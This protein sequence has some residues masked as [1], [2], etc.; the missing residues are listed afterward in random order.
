[1]NRNLLYFHFFAILS[2]YIA[3]NLPEKKGNN[4]KG[5]KFLF[6]FT[7]DQLKLWYLRTSLK[8]LSI[9]AEMA[10]TIFT[11]KGKE[12]SLTLWKKTANKFHQMLNLM[13]LP[14]TLV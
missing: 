11:C 5:N 3:V 9:K 8:F 10:E 12:I 6:A 7:S 1:M 13:D 2:C 4:L 14:P